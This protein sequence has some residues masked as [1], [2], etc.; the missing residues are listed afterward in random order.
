MSTAEQQRTVP[1]RLRSP[2]V[3][4]ATALLTAVVAVA[5][6]TTSN[7]VLRGALVPV[8]VACAVIDL[9][10]RII[11]NRITGPA[12]VLALA[13]GLA[14]DPSGEPKRL[15]WTGIAGGFLLVAALIN[16]AGLGMGDVKLLAVMG[17]FLGAPVIIALLFAL[18]SSLGAGVLI[19][20]RHGV[21]AA[22]KTQLPFGP[23]LALGG[24]F[25]ALLGD[26]ILHAYLHHL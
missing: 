5:Q 1:S 11:P 25:A 15:L 26:Q 17:L 22:R 13:L 6:S 14:L 18:I 4:L 7:A 8:L 20:R 16:P 21:R 10:R 23:Y 12:A 3:L 2:V 9:E 19:A 24:I